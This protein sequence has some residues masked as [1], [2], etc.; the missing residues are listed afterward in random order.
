MARL[1]NGSMRDALSLLDQLISAAE[2]PLSVKS[3]EELLGLPSNE[4]IYL[5][6]E[7]IGQS[8]AGGT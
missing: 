8:D 3:L 7:K 5:L 1:A 4:K 6:L 2:Q